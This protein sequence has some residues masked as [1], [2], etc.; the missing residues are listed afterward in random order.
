[1]TTYGEV[2]GQALDALAFALIFAVETLRVE[3]IAHA[4]CLDLA[5][6]TRQV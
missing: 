3:L 2:F 6:E 4:E 5:V 1:M